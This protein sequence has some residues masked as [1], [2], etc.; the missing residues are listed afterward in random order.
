MVTCYT[1]PVFKMLSL[2][3]SA[4]RETNN[5]SPFK[6]LFNKFMFISRFLANVI[7]SDVIYSNSSYTHKWKCSETGIYIV[8]YSGQKWFGFDKIL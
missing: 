1:A 2:A 4:V 5:V 7:L 8:I 3:I 6:L